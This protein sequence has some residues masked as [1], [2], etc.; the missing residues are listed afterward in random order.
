MDRLAGRAGR[1]RRR[2]GRSGA[3]RRGRE[4]G[5]AAARG[6]SWSAPYEGPL[7]DATAGRV[8]VLEPR[9]R[10]ADGVR[11]A[12]L[13]GRRPGRLGTPWATPARRPTWPRW[14][15]SW[16]PRRCATAP[17]GRCSPIRPRRWPTRM[18]G[19]ARRAGRRLRGDA[20]AGPARLRG[21]AAD[22]ADHGGRGHRPGGRGGARC[23]DAESAGAA[24]SADPLSRRGDRRPG[25]RPA[26]GAGVDAGRRADRG[27]GPDRRAATMST[28]SRAEDVPDGAGG[29][30]GQGR[31]GAVARDRRGRA[32]QQLAVLAVRL[33]M[34]AVYLRLVRG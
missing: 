15:T 6:W 5:C 33:E 16:T 10:R 4:P 28:W 34:A 13:P 12:A 8:A 21:D 17:A 30:G 27:G 14:P 31:R 23:A 25:R 7:R 11:P 19:R 9:I 3:G 24:I 32:E 29:L 20:G 1:R 22:R 18:V 2:P 26:A